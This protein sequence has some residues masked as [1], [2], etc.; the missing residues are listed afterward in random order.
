VRSD[1]L[2][3]HCI[4]LAPMLDKKRVSRK[5]VVFAHPVL[6]ICSGFSTDVCKNSSF[7]ALTVSSAAMS[8][9]Q[10]GQCVLVL[11]LTDLFFF[12]DKTR[13]ADLLPDD[14]LRAVLLC[15]IRI[16]INI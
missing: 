6:W 15:F 10:T 8:V 13:S 3:K 7:L 5:S 14:R 9:W 12:A 4:Q 2:E 1:G 16:R 11:Q